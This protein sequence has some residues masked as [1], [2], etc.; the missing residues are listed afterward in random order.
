M[1]GALG[2]GSTRGWNLEKKFNKYYMGFK[3]GFSNVF[4]VQWLGTRS[5]GFF[6][7]IPQINFLQVSKTSP[8]PLEYDERWKQATLKYTEEISV[9]KLEPIL[10]TVYN[11]FKER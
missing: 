11:L 2:K 5:F 6:L 1:N 3:V 10:E 7:K 9:K 4:G 8:Y